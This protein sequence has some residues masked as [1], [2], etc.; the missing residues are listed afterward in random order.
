[1]EINFMRCNTATSDTAVSLHGNAGRA[2]G[3]ACPGLLFFLFLVLLISGCASVTG[4][5]EEEESPAP[6]GPGKITNISTSE[7]AGSF[8]VSVSGDRELTYTSFRQPTPP[9]VILYFSETL[10]DIPA[11]QSGNK[12]ELFPESEAVS[13][14]KASENKE[15][16]QTARVEIAL[17][18]DLPYQISRE[19]KEVRISFE[20]E[21]SGVR[22]QGSGGALQEENLASNLEPRTP[23][24]IADT[25][26]ILEVW[27]PKRKAWV[28]ENELSEQ[29][30][31]V[32]SS[33]TAS[34]PR[35]PNPEPRTPPATLTP[36]TRI[37]SVYATPLKDSLKV[38]VGADGAISKYKAFTIEAPPRIVF[39]IFNISSP[40]KEEKKVPVNSERVRQ[41]RYY[42]Y[43]DRV[44]VVL[45]T[46][47]SYL[48]KFFAY[49]FQDGLEVYVGEKPA[50]DYQA[51]TVARAAAAN[52]ESVYTTP[53]PDGI[54]IN[55]KGDGTITNYKT[56][57]A[58]NPPRIV[59][60]IFGLRSPYKE[61]QT[62]P[63]DTQWVKRISHKAFPDKIQLTVETQQQWLSDFRAHPDENGLVIRV[64]THKDGF[65]QATA[66][67]AG[68]PA[69]VDLMVFVPEDAGRSTLMLETAS[70]VKYDLRKIA[71]RKLELELQNARISDDR[72]RQGAMDTARHGRAVA[73]VTPVRKGGN[74][75]S[76][77]FEIEL[78][79]SV[80]YFAE[81]S[82]VSGKHF[83]SV[84]FEATSI[85]PV[86]RGTE[87]ALTDKV[88]A[89]PSS[90]AQTPV[91][92]QNIDTQNPASLHETPV[93]RIPA[94]ESRT[95][96]TPDPFSD[97]DLPDLA[98][99]YT[100]EKI[101]MDFFDTDIRNVFRILREISGR[102]FAVDK[103]V[104]GK[105]TLS[106]EQPVPWDQILDLVLKMNQL[107]KTMEGDIVR[108]STMKTILADE[109]LR[110]EKRLSEQKQ[111]EVQPLLTEYI[112]VSYSDARG[113][114]L[115][116]LKDLV[117]KG[118]GSVSVD[119]RTNM[120][121][122]TD[123]A[124]KIRRAKEIIK[125][126]DRV[127]PQVLIEA[128]VVEATSTFSKA[129]GS[130]WGTSGGISNSS[131]AAGIGPQ[132]GYDLLGGTYGYDISV[133]H[134]PSGFTNSIGF[135]FMRLAG[136]ALVLNAKLMAMESQQKGKII[137]SPRVLTLDNK[138][139]T[140][141][142][143]IEVPY[144]VTTTDASGRDK[145]TTEFKNV[146]L[147]L[148][149]T[150]H[151]TPDDRISVKI[152]IVKKDIASIT[153]GTPS[154][155]TKEAKTELLINDGDTI[156]IGGIKKVNT[157]EGIS[158]LPGL[159]KIPLLGWL[160]K[161]KTDQEENQELMIFITPMIVQLEQK[162]T[163]Y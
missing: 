122:F 148:K 94:S 83:L 64:G 161:S 5:K 35:T 37:Q 96:Q 89:L 141:K 139:A 17:K 127:T 8:Y 130:E 159:S 85:P 69:S 125:K 113:E 155:T 46:T 33:E 10:L 157:L 48:S 75:E 140:I 61:E 30:S 57:T 27:D 134:P 73:R 129:L 32:R 12:G 13:S 6:A 156:V 151:V 135:D 153:S 28:P 133:N 102:N 20:K 108:I 91:P 41:V 93:P 80:P 109:K 90:P 120:V 52:L 123:T 149:V 74:G 55:V 56:Y 25:R 126:L 100:G 84:N 103:D 112:A 118:R 162:V 121:I 58:D 132:K 31:G 147:E 70:P 142:Q 72:F 9:A 92:A 40:Y 99:N 128:K 146:D 15:K 144:T 43:P 63:V 114:V 49:P 24:P 29:G 77:L 145:T 1:M 3:I 14:V 110:H 68:P 22:G 66:I 87:I 54:L 150:P 97:I 38:V 11:P 136:S 158:G 76:A 78:A 42:A 21:G 50:G 2:G 107:G 4:L 45:D 115:P 67:P 59:A 111:E 152:S 71:D 131:S 34:A 82:Q 143:G 105:V 44:R 154:L 116:H 163:Q 16:G 81:Y 60:D 119:K 23:N 160:F 65:A 98:P 138:E 19:G 51:P 7:D 106:L 39:D 86:T 117:T 18:K 36:A 104:K 26:P 88:P 62:F 47:K 124:E 137:S 79:E 95:R 53:A 101:A